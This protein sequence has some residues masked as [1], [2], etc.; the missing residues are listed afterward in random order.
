MPVL[1]RLGFLLATESGLPEPLEILGERTRRQESAG[2]AERGEREAAAAGNMKPVQ[3]AIASRRRAS[4]AACLWGLGGGEGAR[5]LS[6]VD[7]RT[8]S[9]E[10]VLPGD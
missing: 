9:A 3:L 1:L 2:R 6:G 7:E 5:E 10:T 8:L 4:P